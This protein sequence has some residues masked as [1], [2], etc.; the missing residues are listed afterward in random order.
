MCACPDFRTPHHHSDP[1]RE[2]P[3]STQQLHGMQVEQLGLADASANK[4]RPNAS[5]LSLKSHAESTLM[6]NKIA[7]R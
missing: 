7:T 1:F 6:P 3:T 4:K 2:W 5:N